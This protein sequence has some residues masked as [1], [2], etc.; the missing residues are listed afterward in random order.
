MSLVLGGSIST[1]LFGNLAVLASA[2]KA[3]SARV[4][5][6]PEVIK[7]F[8][9]AGFP[10]LIARMYDDIVMD[11]R[12]AMEFLLNTEE[13]PPYLTNGLIRNAKLSESMITLSKELV[14]HNIS[15]EE[16]R[17]ISL[18]VGSHHDRLIMVRREARDL[19]R[20]LGLNPLSPL[21]VLVEAL[22][23]DL[24]NLKEYSRLLSYFLARENS[25]AHE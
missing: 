6:Q 9:Q 12:S 10:F 2:V 25:D 20:A 7:A 14:K 1:F 17:I 5:V 11:N 24:I 8:N 23:N 16:A 22:E 4:I 3:T 19:A 18:A 13:L 15:E 21:V